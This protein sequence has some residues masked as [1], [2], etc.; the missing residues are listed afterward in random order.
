MVDVC[1]LDASTDLPAV[2]G[3]L[4]RL[5]ERHE[6]LRT[7][8]RDREDGPQQ[9]VTRSGALALFVHE[10]TQKADDEAVRH[11]VADLARPAFTPTEL[12]LRAA[13]L[14]RDGVPTTLV[15]VVSHLAVDGWS[16]ALVREEV[17]A[18]LAGVEPPPLAQQPTDRARYEASPEARGREQ[19]ALAHWNS[20]VLNL[21]RV[22]LE[23]LPRSPAADDLVC[24][25]IDSHAVATAAAHLAARYKVTPSMV[26]QAGIALALGLDRG[27]TDIGVRLIVATR[28]TA[29]TARFVGPLNQNALLRIALRD[30][31]L[32]DFFTRVRVAALQAL[33]ASEYDP[34]TL[35]DL[36]GAVS[37]RRGFRGDG[38]CFINDV[39][40]YLAPDTPAPHYGR[41]L[42]APT[43]IT[44]VPPPAD[45]KGA[46]L[47]LYVH[48]LEPRARLSV[49]AHRAFLAPGSTAE[50]LGDVEWLLTTAARTDAGPGK[51][52]RAHALRRSTPP[53]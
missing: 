1:P 40:G 18:L 44:D 51:L 31:G 10:I 23:G 7:C 50:F 24:S 5:L 37:A 35:E 34:V 38:Y 12:P 39:T 3:A 14:R 52:A 42:T 21:P 45:P 2:M 47:F 13:V 22:W 16:M 46:N 48:E 11:L 32:A 8:L 28:Y 9:Y 36:V 17:R 41:T 19:A 27:E 29:E 4:A 6:S 43:S 49:I 30:E 26:V 25:K 33:S 15:L 20:T 53:G